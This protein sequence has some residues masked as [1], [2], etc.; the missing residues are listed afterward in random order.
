MAIFKPAIR[1]DESAV[2]ESGN[3]Y[4]NLTID[5]TSTWIVTG[6]STLSTLTNH[7]TIV[8]TDNKVVTIQGADGTVYEE[9]TSPYTITVSTYN[10]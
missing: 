6:N 7:G 1:Q 10:K 9:G 4:A 2:Q 3:G 5:E 8:D